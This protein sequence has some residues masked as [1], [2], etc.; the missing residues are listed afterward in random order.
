[1]NGNNTAGNSGNHTQMFVYKI[2]KKNHDAMRKLLPQLTAI[3]KKHG[4]LS[5]EVYQLDTI[6][7]FEGMKSMTKTISATPDEEAWFELDRYMDSKHRDAVVES[8][9]Q[10][11]EAAPLFRELASLLSRGYSIIMGDF[12]RLDL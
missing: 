11:A 6:A 3:Y 8:V 1:M 4:I 5:W 10:D 12:S 9:M 2:P 7:A